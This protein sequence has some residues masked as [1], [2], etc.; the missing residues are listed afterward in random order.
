MPERLSRTEVRAVR[1]PECGAQPGEN[2]ISSRGKPRESSHQARSHAATLRVRTFSVVDGD[3][4]VVGELVL[5][6]GNHLK[7]GRDSPLSNSDVTGSMKAL[8]SQKKESP[9]EGAESIAAAQIAEVWR[10]WCQRRQ[11]RRT[12]LDDQQAKLIGKGFKADYTAPDL[13]CA[14][15]G[16]LASDW[17]RDR[18]QLSLSTIFSTRPG[19][20][21]L[22]DQVDTWIERG[23]ASRGNGGIEEGDVRTG[24]IDSLKADVRRAWRPDPERPRA[25]EATQQRAADAIAELKSRYGITTSFA[26]RERPVFT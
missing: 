2:C 13:E 3:G 5:R 15:D 16:L 11:P 9:R 7:E 6:E 17:H 24:Y 23:T 10:Y 20:P 4:R 12:E 26:E 19:G 25:D 21:T 14:I 18:K 22:R 1:C 8:A